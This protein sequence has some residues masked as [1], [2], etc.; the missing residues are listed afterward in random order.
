[1]RKGCQ[2]RYRTTFIAGLAIGFI[3]GTRAGRERY[4]QMKKAATQVVQS[5]PVKKA[6]Q[7]AG[8]KAAELT[9]VAKDTAATRVPKLTETARNGA[10]KVRGQFDR[11]PGRHAAPGDGGAE[12]EHAAV[13]G[14]RPA[15]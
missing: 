2:M 8:A 11:L 12:S 6:T 5:P 7:A 1:M 14:T 15:D 3:A 4:E 10:T 9:R 13:N